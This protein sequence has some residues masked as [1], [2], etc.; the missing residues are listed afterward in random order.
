MNSDEKIKN[1]KTVRSKPAIVFFWLCIWQAA[2]FLTDNDIL[3][4]GPLQAASELFGNMITA[5]F[6]KITA[7][8]ALRIGSG[9]VAAF[10][11]GL[12]A[13]SAA[14]RSDFIQAFLEPLMATLKSI[15]VV[16]F[17]VLALIW[18][19]SDMLSFCI[20]FLVVLPNI[21]VNTLEGLKSAD[22]SLLEAAEV[23][24]IGKINRFLFIYRPALMPCL[25]S[26]LEIALG[27]SIKSGVAA[28]II[29]LPAF[30]L[31]ERLY[32]S[33]IYLD[34]AGVF[35]WTFVII[36]LGYIFEKA[37]LYLVKR[38]DAWRPYPVGSMKKGK[39]RN[40]TGYKDRD[41]VLH[42]VSKSYGGEKVLNG[43]S[44]IFK[45][46]GRYCITAPSGAGKTTLLKLLNN[47]E[48]PDEGTMEGLPSYAGMVFQED[49]LFEEYDAIKNIMAAA[50]APY[51]GD[52]YNSALYAAA[53]IREEAARILPPDCLDKPVKELS[54]GM[55]RRC[56][57]LRAVLSDAD[58]IIMDEPFN[59]LDEQ[60]RQKAAAYI[61][62]RLKGRTLIITSHREDDA[63]A[64]DGICIKLPQN[65]NNY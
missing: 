16:S 5:D 1:K 31:G 64:V 7:C 37:V 38:F 50:Q 15:P 47:L 56:A 55:K 52:F 42:G 46:G 23:L 49:R 48:S 62:E 54:G 29:G 14:Y 26:C 58:V 3:L 65:L 6:W 11:T 44:Y 40:A 9:F 4:V 28:E 2:A 34:T 22:K 20:S 30:S 21:Y 45:R 63:K 10:L 43:F 61:L 33:K 36:L 60:N 12:A 17:T 35:S 39:K 41:I 32:M 13:G 19:G 27:M 18:F 8:S 53:Y 57:L 59:G 25:I 24:N 51:D